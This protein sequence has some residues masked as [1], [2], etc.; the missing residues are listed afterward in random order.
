MYIKGRGELIMPTEPRRY[1]P[2]AARGMFERE[3]SS[4]DR[5]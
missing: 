4:V 5:Q 1:G 3:A 2:W